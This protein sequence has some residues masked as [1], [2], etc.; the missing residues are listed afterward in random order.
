MLVLYFVVVISHLVSATLPS[1]TSI[2]TISRTAA[3]NAAEVSRPLV[4]S[5]DGCR[6]HFCLLTLVQSTAK[7]VVSLPET[8]I[9]HA[10]GPVQ[11]ITQ[12]LH[13]V[14]LKHREWNGRRGS[15]GP[16]HAD[17]KSS[18]AQWRPNVHHEPWP[19]ETKGDTQDTSYETSP[20]LIQRQGS[21]AP[22]H[23]RPKPEHRG[24]KRHPKPT[25]FQQNESV[26]EYFPNEVLSALTHRRESPRGSPFH[27]HTKSS[28]KSSS[29]R[30][31]VNA[32][33]TASIYSSTS[34][35]PNC[36]SVAPGA[37]D[38]PVSRDNNS[39]LLFR[40]SC[41]ISKATVDECPYLC[42][43]AGGGFFKECVNEDITGKEPVGEL[44]TLSCTHC[45][46]P[47]DQAFTTSVP[48]KFMTAGTTVMSAAATSDTCLTLD[49]FVG[50]SVKDI[51]TGALLRFQCGL[52][53]QL[54]YECP[55]LC[56][57]EVGKNLGECYDYDTSASNLTTK[58]S[59]LQSIYCPFQHLLGSTPCLIVSCLDEFP[60]GSKPWLQN[61]MLTPHF[62]QDPGYAC[63]HCFYPSRK[64]AAPRPYDEPACTS[65]DPSNPPCPPSVRFDNST[66]PQLRYQTACGT[67]ASEITDCP[68]LCT[69]VNSPDQYHCE[70]EDLGGTIFSPAGTTQV[71]VRCLPEC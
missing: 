40:P 66:T 8:A 2:T 45:L 14:E 3:T 19:V 31:S 50:A 22:G 39:G 7:A 15:P 59:K 51:S 57:R 56:G 9:T 13:R 62:A 68:Y 28:Y 71:C 34:P 36:T 41:G 5:I 63:T 70:N 54:V 30:R 32:S 43:R 29:T 44:P 60:L 49:P 61:A 6:L 25:P 24:S 52:S 16:K 1:T 42:S 23:R 10:L 4:S 67:K 37:T 69:A 12:T 17:P 11:T 47:C 58:V 33:G 65:F 53:F 20:N 26:S 27:K 48:V 64:F 21:P 18:P 46:P 55:Y 35:S 38:G